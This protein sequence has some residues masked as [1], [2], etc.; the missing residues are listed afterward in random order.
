MCAQVCTESEKDVFT[1]NKS[2]HRQEAQQNAT[3]F[4]GTSFA[5][6]TN[7]KVSPQVDVP[8]HLGDAHSPN[9][10]TTLD[11]DHHIAMDMLGFAQTSK[12][13]PCRI[14]VYTD[15][16][17]DVILDG[18]PHSPNKTPPTDDTA[19]N[20]QTSEARP[21][22]PAQYTIHCETNGEGKL[23]LDGNLVLYKRGRLNVAQ[24]KHTGLIMCTFFRTTTS[25]AFLPL[26]RKIF[27]ISIQDCI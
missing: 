17:E 23:V 15:R 10:M 19:T 9:N 3:T 24:A 27:K 7:Q 14:R 21:P 12:P 13:T 11:E 22:S 6:L 2:S 1:G 4:T 5:M 26:L 16:G 8:N 18:D 25:I 20:N